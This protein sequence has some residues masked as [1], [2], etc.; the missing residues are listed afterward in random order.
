[1]SQDF[2]QSCSYCGRVYTEAG[3]FT[4]HAKLCTKGK[5]RLASAL[6]KTREIYRSTKRLHLQVLEAESLQEDT[7]RTDGAHCTERGG[8]VGD[9]EVNICS[10]RSQN[11]QRIRLGHHV[12][13]A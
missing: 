3:P 9:H 8:E 11:A 1:M 5:K 13:R 4:R 7:S 2:S 12:S 6:S 10:N